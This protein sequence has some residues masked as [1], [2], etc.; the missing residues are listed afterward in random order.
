MDETEVLE[1][2]ESFEVPKVAEFGIGEIQARINDG[3]PFSD[4][5]RTTFGQISVLLPV[6][7]GGSRA[8]K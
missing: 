8:A 7:F 3:R 4:C 6:C 1:S 5:G 2:C